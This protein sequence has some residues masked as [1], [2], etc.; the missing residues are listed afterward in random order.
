MFTPTEGAGIGCFLVSVIGLCKHKLTWKGVKL[1]AIDT[2]DLSVVILIL[3]TGIKIFNSYLSASGITT[4]LIKTIAGIATTPITL[5]LLVAG[6][7]MIL[8]M[9]IDTSP[10]MV[11]FVPIL[12]PLVES[13]GISPLQ[14]GILFACC[15]IIGGMSPPFGIVA[16]TMARVVPEM[17][18]WGIFMVGMPYLIMMIVVLIL[19]IF[20]P[21]I[22]TFL[23]ALFS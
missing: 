11:L 9:F 5:L 23:P 8:G 1:A 17:S 4:L 22:S 20:V 3:L 21:G 13:F 7:M 16:Y 6:G 2:I 12:F 10:L 15:G 14:F 19:I 18:L